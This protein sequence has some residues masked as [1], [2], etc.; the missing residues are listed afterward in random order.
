M[1]ESKAKELMDRL[2]RRHQKLPPAGTKRKIPE[3]PA[4][5]PLSSLV[6]DSRIGR[7]QLIAEITQA[8]I[9]VV[10]SVIMSL[11]FRGLTELV[12]SLVS[13]VSF[14]SFVRIAD[15]SLCSP[16]RCEHVHVLSVVVL[17]NS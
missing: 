15:A 12:F 8:V 2:V 4:C 16:Q 6:V 7:R 3:P 9:T 11:S 17:V 5:A 1:P 14:F 10:T 13:V